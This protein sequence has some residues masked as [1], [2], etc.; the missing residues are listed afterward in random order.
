MKYELTACPVNEQ[1]NKENEFLK[2]ELKNKNEVIKLI[3][4]ERKAIEDTPIA[5]CKSK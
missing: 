4:N 2:D 5:N 3:I 1:L